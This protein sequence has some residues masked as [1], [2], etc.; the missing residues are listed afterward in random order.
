MT[1]LFHLSRLLYRQW[2]SAPAL[3]IASIIV[4]AYKRRSVLTTQDAGA[5]LTSVGVA[6]LQFMKIVKTNTCVLYTHHRHI[7]AWQNNKKHVIVLSMPNAY[8]CG[9]RSWP[10][11]N[12]E[13][14]NLSFCLLWSDRLLMTVYTTEWNTE[15]LWPDCVSD[16]ESRVS[17]I[18][19]TYM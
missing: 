19:L 4:N 10:S 16:D 1:S 13:I 7:C 12:N 18:W 11:H 15:S 8:L 3:A 5:A 14:Q 17:M 9:M 6:Y 2:R